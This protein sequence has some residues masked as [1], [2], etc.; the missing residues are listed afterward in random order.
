MGQVLKRSKIETEVPTGETILVVA[1]NV[2]DQELVSVDSHGR[3]L[4]LF[5]ED[6]RRFREVNPPVLSRV[7]PGL[8]FE[9]RLRLQGGVRLGTFGKR[10]RLRLRAV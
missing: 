5:T 2:A 8:W 4:T 6:L 1:F 10:H 7:D 3:M 9:P